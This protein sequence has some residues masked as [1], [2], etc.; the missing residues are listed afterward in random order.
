MNSKTIFLG[1]CILCS[2]S[3]WA[4]VKLEDIKTEELK[5]VS[6]FFKREKYVFEAEIHVYKSG[7]EIETSYI[8]SIKSGDSYYSK[9]SNGITLNTRNKYVVI[10]NGLKRMYFGEATKKKKALTKNEQEKLQKSIL[11]VLDTSE[12]GNLP[13]V[14]METIDKGH[15]LEFVFS[16]ETKPMRIRYLI[17][18]KNG[19]LNKM[20]LDYESEYY[21]RYELVVKQWKNNL[22][23]SDN[24]KLKIEYYITDIQGTPKSK[25]KGYQLIK[26]EE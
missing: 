24:N 20:I 26:I 12:V 22:S 9:N 14:N 19:A 17:N 23:S 4:Q 8:E 1:I 10:L 15:E 13:D 3:S 6:M 21:D 25:M 11:N 5:E 16:S 18:K 7:K 2:I